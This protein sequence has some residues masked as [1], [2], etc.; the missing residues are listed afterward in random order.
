MLRVIARLDVK[1]PNVVKPICFE[2]LRKI[3]EPSALALKYYNQ[4]ADEI[5]YFDIVS[6]LYRRP[7]LFDAIVETAKEI[8]VPFAVGGGLRSIEDCSRLFHSGVDKIVINTFAVQEDPSIIDRAVRIFGTQAVTAHIEAKRWDRWW[9]CFT[10]CGRIPSGRDVIEW[11]KEVQER[12]IGE[13]IVS[14]VDA[15]GR[16]RGFDLELISRLREVCR[17]PLVAASGAG[18]REDVLKVVRSCDVQAVALGSVLHYDLETI[19]S[20]KSFLRENK[21]EVS[22]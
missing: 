17:V 2:G 5:F 12:G 4:G 6:S 22:I 21:V 8:F 15:D 18:S 10:D 3:G 13:I 19:G 9:E 20:I 11:T 7:I 16:K 1:P 14:S